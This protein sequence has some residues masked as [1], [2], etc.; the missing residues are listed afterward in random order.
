MVRVTEAAAIG[1]S[2]LIGRGDEKAADHAAVEAMR[3]ALNE[4][5][6]DGTVVIGESV[7]F[8]GGHDWLR[9]HGVKV[10]DLRDETCIA[11]LP[12]CRNQ[13]CLDNLALCRRD[14]EKIPD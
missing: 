5:A 1:A 14:C 12:D 10:I 7:N 3:A 9:E 4:L 8:H 6:M 2:K 11:M 13:R